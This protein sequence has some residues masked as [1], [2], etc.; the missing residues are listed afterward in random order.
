M[1]DEKNRIDLNRLFESTQRKMVAELTGVRLAVDHPTTLGEQPEVAWVNFLNSILPNRYQA[2]DG[3]VVDA[4]GYR[5]EQ[6]DVLIFDRQYSP[7][8]FQADVVREKEL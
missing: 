5:S 1:T 3:F 8:L 4:D 6:I 2:C 7:P